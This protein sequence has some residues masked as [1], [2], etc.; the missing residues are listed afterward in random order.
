MKQYQKIHI[1]RL[2]C[3]LWVVLIHTLEIRQGHPIAY[4]LSTCLAGQAVPFFFITSGFFLA[5]KLERAERPLEVVRTYV[6][7]NLL[8]YGAWM[9]I[10]LPGVLAVYEK[11]YPDVSVLYKLALLVRRICLAG[12]GVYWY[13]LVLGESAL[14]CGLLLIRKKEKLLYLLTGIGLTLGVIYNGGVSVFGLDHVNQLIYTLW[15][16]PNNLLM[17]GIPL[18]TIGICFARYEA[19]LQLSLRRLLVLYLLIAA[20]S[21][22]FFAWA[23]ASAPELIDWV[24]P[25][26][27]QG[28]LL[29]LMALCP[30]ERVWPQKFCTDCRDLSS[31]IY[32]LHTIF[33]YNV[34]DN[35]VGLFAPVLLRYAI[36]LLPP[37]LIWLIVR[38]L[39]WKPAKWMLA[40]K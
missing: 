33:I 23:K 1:F 13:L 17:T 22:A 27:V 16:W 35:T 2:F 5:K 29:F 18:M 3:A 15:S 11:M 38:K 12:Q 8:L 21:M 10:E 30:T 20:G 9:V 7:H 31:C 39:D 36:G 34:A 19:R 24:M 6:I 25:G 37:V 14:V 40:M 26:V 28:A 32:F 4:M